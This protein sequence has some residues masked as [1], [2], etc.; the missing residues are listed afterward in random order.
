MEDIKKVKII[1]SFLRQKYYFCPYCNKDFKQYVVRHKKE[2]K[3]CF[4]C[5][6]KIKWD[7]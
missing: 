5:G 7:E 4:N 6:N 3:N 1:R 2:Y